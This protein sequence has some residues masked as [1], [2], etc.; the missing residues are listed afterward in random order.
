MLRFAIV[1]SVVILAAVLG[2]VASQGDDA[3]QD[4]FLI[5]SKVDEDFWQDLTQQCQN[6]I[7]DESQAVGMP[8]P[9]IPDAIAQNFLEDIHSNSKTSESTSACSADILARHS[10]QK[11]ERV[12][13]RTISI[14]RDYRPSVMIID[15][16]PSKPL[17]FLNGMI[18]DELQFGCVRRSNKTEHLL[19]QA[20]LHGTLEVR[21]DAAQQLWRGHSRY[22]AGYVLE[23]VFEQ[24]YLENSTFR[25][26]VAA[27]LL[28]SA[29][30]KEIT[31]GDCEWGAWLAGLRPHADVVPVLIECL[32]TKPTAHHAG[33]MFALG[34]SRDE[35]AFGPLLDILQKD[36]YA[37]SGYAA[38]ALGNLGRLEA[39]A[40]LIAVVERGR[41]FPVLHASLALGK[42]GSRNALPCLTDLVETG[43]LDGG[44]LNVR[45]CAQRA[46]EQIE[47]REP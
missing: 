40:P 19:S 6:D 11:E 4:D 39:E 13:G 15:G 8:E 29:L 25:D 24:K 26:E 44:A 17:G 37:Y 5:T 12:A 14:N 46:I 18:P 42:I 16:K 34:K 7:Y 20:L 27:A 47:A 43:R 3:S 23:Y 45:G 2:V 35:R 33:I 9:F 10:P 30:T 38:Q 28:S 32:K 31:E 41:A 1:L 21:L 22:F 36:D